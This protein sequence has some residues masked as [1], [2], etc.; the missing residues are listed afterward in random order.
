MSLVVAKIGSSSVAT[1]EG[2]VNRG[3]VAKL[4]LEIANLRAD[5]HRAVIVTSGAIAIGMPP[6]NLGP[7]RPNR[8][9]LLRA[10]AAVGQM[11]LFRA[12][13]ESLAEHGL[14]AGQVLL[15]PTDLMER[16]RYLGSRETLSA[17]L[18][19]GVV[20]VVNENDAIADDEIKFG[21]NDRLS[22]LVANLVEADQLVLLTDT[23][24]VY[25]ADP[26]QDAHATLI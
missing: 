5:G 10:A 13:E 6:L 1:K 3:A 12:F 23:P 20:P 15:A 11:K 26:R 9:E 22:A 16:H 7:S 18:D 24:G 14:L 25:T 4:C 8:L 21:D 2:S 17:L 19:L